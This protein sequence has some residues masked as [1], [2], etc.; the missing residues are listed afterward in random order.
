MPC[1]GVAGCVLILEQRSHDVL[2]FGLRYRT[3][4]GDFGTQRPD[5]DI[6]YCSHRGAGDA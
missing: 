2:R 3:W 5:D 4:R 6:G 1:F